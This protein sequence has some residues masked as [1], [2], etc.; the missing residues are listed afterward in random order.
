MAKGDYDRALSALQRCDHEAAQSY[1]VKALA[2]VP[3]PLI[4]CV[5]GLSLLALLSVG[6]RDAI[7]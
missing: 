4:P 6:K 3:E 2:Y 1:L 7:S 5:A